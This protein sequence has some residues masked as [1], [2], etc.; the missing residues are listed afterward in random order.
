MKNQK[1]KAKGM[2]HMC[3][4]QKIIL[5]RCLLL[6]M[7]ADIIIGAIY[8]TKSVKAESENQN[9]N[10]ELIFCIPEAAVKTGKRSENNTGVM[11]IKRNFSDRDGQEF[12]DIS[13]EL[14][15]TEELPGSGTYDSGEQAV[16]TTPAPTQTVIESVTDKWTVISGKRLDIILVYAGDTVN[17]EKDGLSLNVP[18]N[19]VRSW[20][21]KDSETVQVCVEK[22]DDCTY[23]ILIFKGDEE[24]YDIPGSQ[25]LIPVEEV[26]PEEDPETLK[27]LDSKWEVMDTD[28]DRNGDLLTVET[29]KTGIY[30]I[31][32]QKADTAKMK[33]ST[34]VAVGMLGVIGMTGIMYKFRRR[35]AGN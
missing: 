15:I 16:K 4:L 17:F 10:F 30:H 1:N 2:S 9:R 28:F 8:H 32:S 18:E 33:K 27:V 24:I 29:D 3:N 35:G 19:I 11:Q 22:T 20:D 12:P 6:F 7:M 34:A 23:E 14:Y 26:F 5:C 13:Q 25:V 21:I 31:K